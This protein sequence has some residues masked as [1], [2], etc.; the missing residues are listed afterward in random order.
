[1]T[2]VKTIRGKER[3]NNFGFL[4]I[5]TITAS[6][7]MS[8]WSRLKYTLFSAEAAAERKKNLYQV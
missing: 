3:I 6:K 8:I 5:M 2:A 4:G 1:M 7:G